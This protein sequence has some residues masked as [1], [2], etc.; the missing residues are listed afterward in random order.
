MKKNSCIL[1]TG[2]NGLAGSAVVEHLHEHLYTCVVSV[3]HDDVD[4]RDPV[5]TLEVFDRIKPEYVF[6]AAAT[7]YGIGGNMAFQGKSILENTL[8]NT[9]VIDAS[10]RNGVKKIIVMGTNA[11][12]PWP[13][14]LPYREDDIFNGR[15]HG[16]EAAYGHAKR[17]MLA[18]LEAYHDSYDLDYVYLV[19]GNLYGP[20][21][22]FDPVYGHV[23]PSLIAK[24][25]D[26]SLYP[27]CT[28]G[29]IEI[30]GDGSATR[31]F[32]YSKDLAEGVRLTMTED[33]HGAIN[34][35]HGK[36][37]SI[38]EIAEKLTLISGVAPFRVIYNDNKPNGR[39]NCYADLSKL[40]TLGFRPATTMDE[41]LQKTWD[42]FVNYQLSHRP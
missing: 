8:I 19:S 12:Y 16:A 35:G 29:D 2:A 4:L 17:H 24:F 14:N 34:V 11:I 38:R 7:V 13:P 40:K 18:M 26:A 36:T 22:R 21:D 32:L 1:V 42:W 3:T 9:S 25:Y 31:D 27:D 10:N 41:G 39:P 28:E 30:W 6:H 33:V 37:Y 20:R 15:P 5:R 23:L